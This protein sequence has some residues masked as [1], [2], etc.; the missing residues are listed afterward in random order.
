MSFPV[1]CHHSM[2]SETACVFVSYSVW[3]VH[4]VNF[5]S[6]H[7]LSCW[8]CAYILPSC[9]FLIR[10]H[11]WWIVDN[12]LE[13]LVIPS[14]GGFTPKLNGGQTTRAWSSVQKTETMTTMKRIVQ[15]KTKLAGGLTGQVGPWVICHRFIDKSLGSFHELF[16]QILLIISSH[17]LILSFRTYSAK[18]RHCCTAAGYANF[19]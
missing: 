18:V 4:H 1:F 15:K 9:Q 13:Q 19:L 12:T 16:K 8:D 6:E 7:V 3:L 14:L 11:T 2:L 17:F 10:I 5:L